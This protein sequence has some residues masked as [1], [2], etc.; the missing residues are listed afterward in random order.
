MEL[1]TERQA[2]QYLQR[3]HIGRDAARSALKAGVAGAPIEVR[4][5]LLYH[6]DEVKAVL[7][8]ADE[9]CQ[10]R[11]PI[12]PADLRRP[13]WPTDTR[14]GLHVAILARRGRAC[15]RPGATGRS[16]RV[17]APR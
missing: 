9:P 17:V 3:M 15:A 16:P 14:P 8:R 12:R 2:T 7:D 1:W 6:A 10:I 11:V 13:T 5:S 4:N